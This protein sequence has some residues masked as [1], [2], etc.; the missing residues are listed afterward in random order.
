MSMV[1]GNAPSDLISRCC[2]DF[3]S[4]DC[5]GGPQDAEN[6]LLVVHI[7]RPPTLGNDLVN[8]FLTN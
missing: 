4:G 1:V 8:L 7:R 2:L 5:S 6:D 3:G